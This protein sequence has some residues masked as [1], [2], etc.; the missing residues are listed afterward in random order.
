M[1]SIS[2]DI[3][4]VGNGPSVLE[5]TMG[6]KIDSFPLV[7]RFNVFHI[8]GFEKFVGTKTNVWITCAD[9][10]FPDEQE[11]YDWIVFTKLGSGIHKN[12]LDICKRFNYITQVGYSETVK[13]VEKIMGYNG[14][15][16]GAM[17][18]MFFIQ[19][20]FNVFLY[21]FDHFSTVRHHYGDTCKKGTV[22][23]NEYELIFFN[24]MLKEGKITYLF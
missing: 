6:K 7:A 13:E 10:R 9:Y 4:L 17:A 18:T 5:K 16:S 24:K 11:D 21:G 15:S 2:K 20:G 19:M 3:V 23:K 1:S 12:F 8:R 22:H 14:P